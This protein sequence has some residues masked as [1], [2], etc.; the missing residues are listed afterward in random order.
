MRTFSS[1][2]LIGKSSIADIGNQI[3]H[4]P[5]SLLYIFYYEPTGFE[6]VNN[7]SYK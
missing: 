1:A 6:R 5:Q 2:Y 4:C 7:L 3:I